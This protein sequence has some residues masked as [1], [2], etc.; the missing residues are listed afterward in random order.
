MNRVVY[1][2]NVRRMTHRGIKNFYRRY[3]KEVTIFFISF[4]IHLAVSI[5]LYNKFGDQVLY[6][7][8]EDAYSYVR[9]AQ[10][11]ARGEGFAYDGVPSPTRTP[12]YPL[13]LSV[14]YFLHL[15]FVWSVLLFQNIIASCSGILVYRLGNMLFS[16]RAGSYASALYILEPYMLMTANLATTETFFNFILLCFIFL[17]ARWYSGRGSLTHLGGAGM[18]AGFTLLTRPIVLYLPLLA[19]VLIATRYFFVKNSWKSISI[20][21]LIFFSACLLVIAPWSLRQHTLFG[22]FKIT[23]IDASM[24]YFKAAPVAVAARDGVTYD[25]ALESL[26]SE[27]QKKFPG[28][29]EQTMNSSFAYYDYMARESKQLIR[30]NIG[31]VIRYYFFSLIPALSGTGYEYILETVVGVGRSIPRVS[32]TDVLFTEGARG[33]ATILRRFDI[34]QAVTFL[35]AGAWGFMYIVLLFTASKKE[36]WQGHGFAFFLLLSLIGYFVF[37][38][39]GPAIHA[40]YRMPTFPLWFLLFGWSIDFLVKTYILKNQEIKKSW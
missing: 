36:A 39:V 24:L 37:F 27:L 29:T 4:G 17:F 34:F 9:L 15:P 28:Y 38:S 18:C 12:V 8:N 2:M 20:F 21:I 32:Y 22:R 16:E 3:R 31:A 33:V 26:R 10:S 11:V 40:R 25:A 14:F 13:V 1:T 6:F 19:V 23:N 5:F 7:E 30:E 35:G